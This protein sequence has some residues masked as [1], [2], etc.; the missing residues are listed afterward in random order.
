MAFH[1]STRW[2]FSQHCTNYKLKQQAF[3]TEFMIYV[4]PIFKTDNP[5]FP[6]I[7]MNQVLILACSLAS[8]LEK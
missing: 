4:S 6:E 7:P 1:F 5:T 8:L 2:D 3:K